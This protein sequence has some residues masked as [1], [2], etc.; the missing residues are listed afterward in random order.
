VFYVLPG[1]ADPP[2]A[3]SMAAFMCIGSCRRTNSGKLFLFI[4]AQVRSAAKAKLHTCGKRKAEN[5]S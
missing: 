5:F 4:T 3:G 2:E 1:D